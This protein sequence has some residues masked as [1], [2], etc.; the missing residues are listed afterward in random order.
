MVGDLIVYL[1]FDD[2]YICPWN[3]LISA[4]FCDIFHSF[5]AYN[6]DSIVSFKRRKYYITVY[7]IA[8]DL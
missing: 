6:A 1:K 2:V 4:L 5:V 3:S 7:S 8:L